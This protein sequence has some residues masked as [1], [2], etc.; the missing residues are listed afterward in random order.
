[1]RPFESPCQARW[2]WV[3][4]TCETCHDR[5][6]TWGT[7]NFES[8][9]FLTEDQAIPNTDLAGLALVILEAMNRRFTM[10]RCSEELI[11]TVRRSKNLGLDDMSRWGPDL[12]DFVEHLVRGCDSPQNK[13]ATTVST[14]TIF[15]LHEPH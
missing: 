10:D 11:E 6:L 15:S 2:S 5:E 9:T 13:V 3:W 14:K 1:M 8:T 7:G 4:T 12:I